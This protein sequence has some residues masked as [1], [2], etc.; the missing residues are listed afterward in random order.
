M[1]RY[2]L[3]L[4]LL[5]ATTPFAYANG[6]TQYEVS[7]D[8]AVHHEAQVSATFKDIEQPILELRMSRSSPGRYAIHE[9]A[10]NIYMLT[11]VNGAGESLVVKRPN[12]YQWNVVGHDGTVTVSYTL[13][14]DHADGTYSG[15]DRTHA[16]LNIPATFIWARG[17]DQRQVEIKLNPFDPDWKV[18]TQLLS[19]K[20]QYEFTA[21]NLQYFMD[22]PIEM[23]NFELRSWKVNSKG[24]DY[25]I[26]LAVHH[27]G[28]PEEMDDYT[29]RAKAIVNA[30]IDIFGELPDF[31]YGE[32]IFIGCF[33]P[34]VV[35]DGMEHRNSTILTG[36]QSFDQADFSQQGVLAH[37]FLHAWNAERIRPK[38]L[39]PFD[40]EH[41][42]MSEELWFVEGFTSYYTG[43]VL[44]RANLIKR[45][46]LYS[47]LVRP[48]SAVQQIPGKKMFSA[49][50]MSRQAPFRDAAIFVDKT[51]FS[52][53]LIS[54]YVIGGSVAIALDLTLRTKFKGKSLDSFMKLVWKKYGQT[55]INY[56]NRD[57][58][59]T[60]AELVD[61]KAF[62]EMF[63]E[64]YVL[65]TEVPD[66]KKLLAKM[67]LSLELKNPKT[68]SLG[69]ID[70]EFNGPE[71]IVSSPTIMG[72][73]LYQAGVDS[74]DHIISIDQRKIRSQQ[75]WE[76]T[77]MKYQPGDS[78]I[79]H[80]IQRGV[81]VSS[82]ITF[83]QDPSLKI[84][85]FKSIDKR[86]TRSMKKRR[87]LWLGKEHK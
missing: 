51:N 7:F 85:T 59:D 81:K 64:K 8:N 18:A 12:P 46:E 32:Y 38:S 26:K 69:K 23:S 79:I 27:E 37:E 16:H 62:A 68:A 60:L 24:K 25:T 42:N 84:V 53:T 15:I 70:I 6:P 29:Q 19:T 61:D 66:Y 55:E 21:P 31:D 65:G 28:T 83:M 49:S 22:S 34:H 82:K 77:L 10:K 33:L 76:K 35:G 71:A 41:A 87:S 86:E 56:S 54:H 52:N 13:Y 50:G 2:L 39:E 40:F 4:A 9:F 11:A 45:H 17:F 75:A 30:E 36:S 5:V 74:G 3:I 47:S 57:L 1:T 58:Q 44:A 73:P 80:Y 43:L 48:I 20:N 14:A 72:T 63:F 67:G 78:A